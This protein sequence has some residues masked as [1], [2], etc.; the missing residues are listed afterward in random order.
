MKSV[1]ERL[2][3]RGCENVIFGL[4][5]LPSTITKLRVGHESAPRIFTILHLDPLEPKECI[6]A[7]S[8]GMQIANEK[9]EKKTAISTEALDMLADLSEGYP[10]FIQQFAYSAFEA[11][12]D[13]N[14]DVDDVVSGAYG[15]NGAIHQLGRKYFSEVYFSKIN[16]DDY[17]KLLNVMA[18][19]GDEWVS[20]QQLLR[21][22]KLKETTIN[23]ALQALK[24]KSIILSDESRQGFYRLPTRSFAAW[25]NALKTAA[26]Q[27]ATG[28]TPQLPLTSDFVQS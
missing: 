28:K 22:S 17:R 16:S 5:G 26:A 10:H 14:I 15:E 3:R 23:N 25:I 2:T 8:I 6:Q 9:N 20:R 7:I 19:H 24:Q 13:L 1:T 18:D 27:R 11:D 12:T 4:A 21:E